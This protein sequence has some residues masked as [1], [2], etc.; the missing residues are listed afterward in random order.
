MYCFKTPIRF[1]II[2]CFRFRPGFSYRRNHGNPSKHGSRTLTGNARGLGAVL[3][4]VHVRLVF[5]AA[6][7]QLARRGR[8]Q[9][10]K[11][12]RRREHVRG[13]QLSEKKQYR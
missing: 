8:R 3:V 11:I 10:G 6:N 4:D 9:V 1:I 2:I 13:A 7:F 5:D 12:G